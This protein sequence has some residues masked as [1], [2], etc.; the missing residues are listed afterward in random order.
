MCIRDRPG[1]LYEVCRLGNLHGLLHLLFGGVPCA[2]GHV[3]SNGAGEHDRPLGHIA[4]LLVERFQGVLPH[5]YAVHQ[6]L[7]LGGVI[8]PGHQIDE[9]GFARAGGSDLSLIHI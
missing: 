8:K 2:V 3:G 4:Q 6:D 5:V 1:A 9:T 7:P